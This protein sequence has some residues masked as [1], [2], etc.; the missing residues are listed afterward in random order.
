LA[1]ADTTGRH[2]LA[3]RPP[4]SRSW[5]YNFPLSKL[6]TISRDGHHVAPREAFVSFSSH[7][8]V[9]VLIPFSLFVLSSCFSCDNWPPSFLV[10]RYPSRSFPFPLSLLSACFNFLQSFCTGVYFFFF[11]PFSVFWSRPFLT[12]GFSFVILLTAFPFFQQDE[13]YR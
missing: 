9:G 12:S 6:S 5:Y 2:G 7:C 11:L 3:T 8:G 13:S 10:Y 1:S 4:L